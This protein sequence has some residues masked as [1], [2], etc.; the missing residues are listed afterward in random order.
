MSTERSK[1]QRWERAGA[2]AGSKVGGGIA[3]AG[4]WVGLGL[5]FGLNP[6]A[7]E[8]IVG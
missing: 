3:W 7:F 4:F 8:R 1:D 2:E 6:E 5:L